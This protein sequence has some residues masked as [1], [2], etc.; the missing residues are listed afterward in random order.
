MKNIT[1]ILTDYEVYHT[2]PKTKYSHIIGV[3]LIVLSLQMA[4][5]WLHV[6]AVSFALIFTLGLSVYY[7]WLEVKLGIVTDLLLLGLLALAHSLAGTSFTLNGLG[8]FLILFVG[9]WGLQLLGHYHEGNKPAFLDN[10]LQVFTAPIFVVA[11]ILF[12]LGFRK[13]LEASILSR[14]ASLKK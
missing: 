14:A 9:G 3:P 6:G 2:K 4:L 10:F 5:S 1:D 8:I 13:D 7:L 12:N 11:E